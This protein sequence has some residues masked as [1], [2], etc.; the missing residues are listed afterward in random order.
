MAQFFSIFSS[1]IDSTRWG[2]RAKRQAERKGE[3]SFFGVMSRDEKDI[4]ESFRNSRG[5][6]L[7]TFTSRNAQGMQILSCQKIPPFCFLF[8]LILNIRNVC[9][10]FADT[11]FEQ[12]KKDNN[13]LFG[14]KTALLQFSSC[15]GKRPKAERKLDFCLRLSL[16]FRAQRAILNQMP[17]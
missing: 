12:R 1:F 6:F 10:K 2:D 13:I 14:T 17:P 4:L 5:C 8:L 16:G 3:R 15:S 11:Y 7:I 9:C